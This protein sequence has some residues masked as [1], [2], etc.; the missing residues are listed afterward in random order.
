M[1]KNSKMG[2][3]KG[4]TPDKQKRRPGGGQPSPVKKINFP[5]GMGSNSKKTSYRPQGR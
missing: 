3:N 4:L 2:P 1:A 5:S